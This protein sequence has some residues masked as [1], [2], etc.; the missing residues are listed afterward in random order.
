MILR[1]RMN[2]PKNEIGSRSRNWISLCAI[3]LVQRRK[4]KIHPKENM[5]SVFVVVEMLQREPGFWNA[6]GNVRYIPTRPRVDSPALL[7]SWVQKT[8][9][10]CPHKTR[11]KNQIKWN[12]MEWNGMEWNGM[13]YPSG[14]I[15]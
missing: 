7:E 5:N 14:P 2:L 1:R 10:S 3:Y 9:P 15:F 13:E 8:S 6:L 12:G 4:M 11:S